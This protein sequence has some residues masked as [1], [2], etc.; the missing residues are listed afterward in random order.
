M[1]AASKALNLYETQLSRYAQALAAG[2]IEP[3]LPDLVG[4]SGPADVQRYVDNAVG[5]R[6]RMLVEDAQL[7]GLVVDGLETKALDYIQQTPRDAYEYGRRETPRFLNWLRDT[8]PLS[9]RQLDFVAYQLAEFA[10]L[11]LAY[12]CR[13]EYLR[14]VAA[15]EQQAAAQRCLHEIP[16]PLLHINP[17][18][19]WSQLAVASGADDSPI[20]RPTLFYAHGEQIQHAT[21]DASRV[22]CW[23]RL[24]EMAPCEPSAW[25]RAHGWPMVDAMTLAA[26]WI[27][28]GLI[29]VTSKGIFK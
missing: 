4:G 26:S 25:A 12:E 13:D 6:V 7:V 27:E 5:E 17:V 2:Q 23:R 16:N 1:H 3:V 20:P 22:A 14:F 24:E 9:A 28:Q 8:T 18:R 19:V 10:C 21:L 15:R 11:E 29:A